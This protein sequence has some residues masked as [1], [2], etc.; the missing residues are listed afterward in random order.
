MIPQLLFA[1]FVGALT[2][3][4]SAAVI[5][6]IDVS[7][8]T[9]TYFCGGCLQAAPFVPCYAV[10]MGLTEEWPWRA[11]VGIERTEAR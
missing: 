1:R 7:T 4:C 3:C 8:N 10:R 6:E 5:V 11:K 2:E 9:A